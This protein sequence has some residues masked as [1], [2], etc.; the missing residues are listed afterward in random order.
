MSLE[1]AFQAELSYLRDAGRSFAERHPA[2]AGMLSERG[3]DPDVE[4]LLQGFAFVSARLRRRIDD[5]APELGEALAEWIMPHAVRPQPAATL[6]EFQPRGLRGPVTLAKGARLH[7][8]GPQRCTFTTSEALTLMP[9]SL[10]GCELRDT[11]LARPELRLQLEL[12]PHAELRCLEASPVRVQL[13]GEPSVSAQLCL[14]L[15]RHLEAVQVEAPDGTLHELG[16]RSVQVPDLS[17]GEPLYPWPQVAPHSARVLL[18][19]FAL[20]AK[21]QRLELRELGRAVTL[22]GRRFTLVL[23]FRDPPPLPARPSAR[24]FRLHCVPAVNLFPAGAEP[25]RV[26][27]SDRPQLLRALGLDPACAEVFSVDSVTGIPRRGERRSYAPLHA[28]RDPAESGGFYKLE[29]RLA[30]GDDGTLSWLS[31]HRDARAAWERGEETLSVELTCTNR[32]LARALQPGDL[33]EPSTDLPAG[34][35]F[36]NIGTVSPPAQPALGH[37]RMWQLLSHLACSRR[38]L[39][40]AS[41]LRS[42]LALYVTDPRSDDTRARAQRGCIDAIRGVHAETVTRVLGGVAARGSR[43]EVELDGRAFSSE[44]EAF[45]FGAMLHALFA[46]DARINTFA[47]LCVVLAPSGRSFRYDTEWAR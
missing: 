40:E 33:C 11:A 26:D 9:L 30:E 23:R 19:S 21:F 5:A 31:L 41:V 17:A 24:M 6:I 28:F 22:A 36:E 12:E 3:A 4:R 37:A 8:R 2:L 29:R 35:R 14:W 13:H 42:V 1:S 38:S 32:G 45:A 7:S 10:L 44:G 46:I 43:Y 39:A 47:D 25:L 27:L 20:P 34:V 18:E 16:T 15:A